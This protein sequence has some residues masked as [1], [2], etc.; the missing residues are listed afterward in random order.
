MEKEYLEEV[1]KCLG[2]CLETATK[3]RTLQLLKVLPAEPDLEK[4]KGLVEG[5]LQ[6]H[7]FYKGCLLSWKYS[8]E[9]LSEEEIVAMKEA[10]ID[11]TVEKMNRE[12]TKSEGVSLS[13]IRALNERRGEA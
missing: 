1:L 6:L 12:P 11:P 7:D 9:P 2:S 8:G 13:M 4:L 5:L 3:T 10:G